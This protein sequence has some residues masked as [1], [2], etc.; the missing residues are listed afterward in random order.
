MT[1][2]YTTQQLRDFDELEGT[3]LPTASPVEEA[4][5]LE[6]GLTSPPLAAA[7][8]IP[9]EAQARIY[10]PQ[11]STEA[12]TA[13]SEFEDEEA[14]LI[15]L[16]PTDERYKCRHSDNRRLAAAQ[17]QGRL[18]ATDEQIHVLRNNDTIP[19]YNNQVNLV[20]DRANQVAQMENL[21]E[22]RLRNPPIATPPLETS[23]LSSAPKE[24]PPY[25]QSHTK[26]K[27]YQ[28]KEYDVGE[29]D[30]TGYAYETSEYKSDYD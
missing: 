3:L 1:A 13:A 27:G 20:L 17:F 5:P 14:S 30:D 19:A 9:I 12:L 6:S 24:E 15:P 16:E 4:G 21:R 29:Y 2:L 10:R 28:V 25:F 18:A 22:Q 8:A 23:S 7:T 11:Q 26:G